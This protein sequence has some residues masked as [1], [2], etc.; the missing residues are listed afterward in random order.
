[1]PASAAKSAKLFKGKATSGS[2]AFTKSGKGSD[3]AV[4]EEGHEGPPA[5]AKAG[6]VGSTSGDSKAGKIGTTADD[7]KAKKVG[8][9]S[10]GASPTSAQSSTAAVVASMRIMERLVRVRCQAGYQTS[11]RHP[12]P[13]HCKFIIIKMNWKIDPKRTQTS[14][15]LVRTGTSSRLVIKVR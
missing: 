14:S 2:T 1:M 11:R 8:K 7:A 3:Y 13:V 9:S 5:D 4:G 10:G 15:R 6:K 12:E